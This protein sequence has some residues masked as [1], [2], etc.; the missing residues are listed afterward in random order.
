MALS[1]TRLPPIIPVPVKVKPGSRNTV[2]HPFDPVDN[3][4]SVWFPEAVGKSNVRSPNEV[5]PYID[6]HAAFKDMVSAMRTATKRG[7]FIYLLGWRLRTDFRLVPSDGTTTIESILTTASA[8]NVDIR[9]MLYHQHTELSGEDNTPAIKFINELFNGAAIHDDRVVK[10]GILADLGEIFEGIKLHYVGMHHQKVLIINGKEGLI[11]FQGGMDENPDRLEFGDSKTV[12]LHDVHTRHRGEAA[13]SLW[14]LFVERW[15]DHPQ[16][17][18]FSPIPTSLVADPAT[19]V[20]DN[21]HVEIG[22][23]YPNSKSHSLFGPG[24]PYSFAATG[25]QSAKALVLNAISQSK[26]FIYIEDQYLFDMSISNALKAA[27][28]NLK[29]LI[30]FITGSQQIP[31][32]RQPFSRR[33]AFIDNLTSGVQPPT[34]KVI[35]CANKT[36][37]VHSKTFIFDDKFAIVG[38]ANLTRRGYSHDSEQNAGIFDTN[39]KKRF[40]FAHELRMNLWAKHL[41]KR[42]IDLVDPIASSVH[43][44]KPIG[45]VATYVVA[46]AD[47]PQKFPETVLKDIVWNVGLDPDGT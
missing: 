7:H 19:Q 29:K 13:G 32:Q 43:W 41:L 25:D 6:G 17:A 3:N 21:L 23:T 10:G 40:F 44:T 36:G 35:V 22:R 15:Q 38:S 18:N 46:G 8:M 5:I 2:V 30:I 31:D 24:G 12:G 37:Y 42:P 47:P 34:N 20:S 1:T 39:P 28:P 11:A 9:V 27:L 16:S 26:K 45:N 4:A 33:K 14:K